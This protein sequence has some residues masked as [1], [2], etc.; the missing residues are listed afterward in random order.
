MRYTERRTGQKK[1][2]EAYLLHPRKKYVI[3]ITVKQIRPATLTA[4]EKKA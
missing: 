4:K 2:N 3:I 1:E